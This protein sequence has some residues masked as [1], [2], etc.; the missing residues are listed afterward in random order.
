MESSEGS[1]EGSAKTSRN[2]LAGGFKKINWDK[3]KTNFDYGGGKYN[4]GTKYLKS[5]GVNNVI[6][7]PYN[8]DPKHNALAWRISENAEV[9]TL[10]NV[11]NVIPTKEERLYILKQAARKKVR[12]IYIT[13]YEKNK[14]GKG[15]KTRDGWQNNMKLKDYLDEIQEIYPDAELSNNMITIKLKGDIYE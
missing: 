14:S 8:R 9:S 6:F 2:Q 11:L 13:V 10:F 3:I 15:H 4:K 1:S 7:D 12:R 5:K